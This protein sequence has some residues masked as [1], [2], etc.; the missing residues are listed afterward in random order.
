MSQASEAT[1]TVYDLTGRVVFTQNLTNL[2]TESINQVAIDVAKYASGLYTVVV[3]TE[4]EIAATK[5]LKQ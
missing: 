1:I 2:E 4:N 3:E 5:L